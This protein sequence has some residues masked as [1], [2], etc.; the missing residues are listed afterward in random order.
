MQDAMVAA[1]RA[2]ERVVPSH[3]ADAS[4]VATHRAHELALSGV[5]DLKLASVSSNGEVGA[6]AGPLDAGHSVRGAKVTEPR[7]L[8]VLG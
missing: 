6:V 2:K 5:P 7:D 4:I 8:A 3:S 1:T